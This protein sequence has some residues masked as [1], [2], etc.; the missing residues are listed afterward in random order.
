[1]NAIPKIEFPLLREI[2]VNTGIIINDPNK[3]SGN[4]ICDT[5]YGK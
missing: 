5:R 3:N 2:K 1:M 4:L